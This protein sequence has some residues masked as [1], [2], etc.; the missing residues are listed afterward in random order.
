MWSK[1]RSIARR[2]RL[3]LG[4]DAICAIGQAFAP[5]TTCSTQ[6]LAAASVQLSDVSPYSVCQRQLAVSDL[7][8]HCMTLRRHDS[9]VS[10]L[11][12]R[13][14]PGQSRQRPACFLGVL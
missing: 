7:I 2:T 1:N 4:Y 6:S 5:A 3:L 13:A 9:A 12:R 11:R 8:R 10:I 14:D